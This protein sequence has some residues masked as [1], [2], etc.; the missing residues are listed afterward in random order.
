MKEIHTFSIEQILCLLIRVLIRLSLKSINKTG[1]NNT[2][3][4]LQNTFTI[5]S[6][7]Q[8]LIEK[9]C[10]TD[11]GN[12]PPDPIQTWIWLMYWYL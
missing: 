6:Q 5:T 12:K 11:R 2:V 3:I 7:L 4:I 1:A 9:R 10:R 8:M